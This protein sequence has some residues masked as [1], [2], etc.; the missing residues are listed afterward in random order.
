VAAERGEDPV[1]VSTI[2]KACRKLGQLKDKA[3]RSEQTCQL[4]KLR[5]H[6]QI[7]LAS[8]TPP[9]GDPLAAVGWAYLRLAQQI[10]A[11][12]TVPRFEPAAYILPVEVCA[13]VGFLPNNQAAKALIQRLEDGD[14]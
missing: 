6:E 11:M 12:A 8:P 10:Y 5:L 2:H 13:S 14:G 3:R 1:R 9:I 7:D 4:R